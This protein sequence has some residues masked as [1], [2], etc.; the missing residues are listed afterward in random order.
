MKFHDRL[1]RLDPH[2][3]QE[4]NPAYRTY[5]FG[6]S[7]AYAGVALTVAGVALE[8][9]SGSKFGIAMAYGGGFFDVPGGL[10]VSVG[11]G[12]MSPGEH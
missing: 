9:A 5:R 11:V 2:D 7:W 4:E 3:A 8:E 12:G 6:L 1:F 10:A